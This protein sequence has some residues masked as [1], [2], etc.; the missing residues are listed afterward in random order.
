MR[1]KK[2]AIILMA[3]GISGC[4][5]MP[6]MSTNY[7]AGTAAPCGWKAVDAGMCPYVGYKKPSYR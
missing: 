1:R 7:G 6:P 3:L 5:A 2:F 4:Q